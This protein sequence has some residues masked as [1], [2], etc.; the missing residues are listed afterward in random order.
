MQENQFSAPIQLGCRNMREPQ[1]AI[2]ETLASLPAH[3]D[4]LAPPRFDLAHSAQTTS[5]MFSG[6]LLSSASLG[7]Q[8]ARIP[9][10]LLRL[11]LVCLP[12]VVKRLSK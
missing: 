3:F 10:E 8:A 9:A 4:C 5:W 11:R 1:E 6:S 2:G 12:A 7:F